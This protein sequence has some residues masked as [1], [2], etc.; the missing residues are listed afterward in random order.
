M[1]SITR[2]ARGL[3]VVVLLTLSLG[4]L[5]AQPPAPADDRV[6]GLVVQ[7]QD[8]K[9]EVRSEAAK[10]LRNNGITV[11]DLLTAVNKEKDPAAKVSM[12]NSLANMKNSAVLAVFRQLAI[13]KDATVRAAALDG[14]RGTNEFLL[15]QVS[16]KL[17]RDENDIVRTKA[18]TT[19]AGLND[20]KLVP[21]LTAGLRIMPARTRRDM[22][23]GLAKYKGDRAAFTAVF[24]ALKD[25]DKDVRFAAITALG[26][27]G[28]HDAIDT[29]IA[30]M[31]EKEVDK[32]VRAEIAIALGKLG[33]TDAIVPLQAVL[34]DA[35]LK[36]QHKAA[37][38]TL[39][40]FGR[41]AVGAADLLLQS[42]DADTRA[43]GIR[44]LAASQHNSAFGGILAG[45]KDKDAG[46]RMASLEAFGSYRNI[47]SVNALIPFL[48]DAD[49]KVRA[50]AATALG[51]QDTYE[52]VLPVANMVYRDIN[53]D[54]RHA[55][56]LA[57]G[58]L[59]NR[60]VT[61]L[62]LTTLADNEKYTRIDS[63]LALGKVGDYR[64][65]EPLY[66]I[67][68]R[69]YPDFEAP[70]GKGEYPSVRG[71]AAEAL[72]MQQVDKAYP[73]IV[74]ALHNPDYFYVRVSAANALASLG[75]KRAIPELISVLDDANSNVRHAAV[76]ALKTLTGDD[77]GEDQAAWMKR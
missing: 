16:L 36:S 29:L 75:D 23:N 51:N 56:I 22:I 10:K 20:S 41:K 65:I 18:L 59:N 27:L 70:K 32:S 73:L 21:E 25:E 71:A 39:G 30:K 19:L 67:L 34:M 35:T 31:N 11:N 62:L 50:A 47:Y 8:P 48:S 7:L 74:A 12:I 64:A 33:S 49:P 4:A 66:A 38:A 60:T 52:A 72:G 26:N 3:M 44:V 1:N 14:L 77:F 61:A 43:N 40:N 68:Q 45:L 9:P 58:N 37:I 15:E 63:A 17:V 46:V 2:A 76:T 54:A 69:D 28:N 57:L 6:K 42:K 5:F 53:P 55:G 13:D 24:A